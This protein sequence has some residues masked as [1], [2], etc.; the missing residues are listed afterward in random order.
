MT[1]RLVS[2]DSR[3]PTESSARAPEPSGRV[4]L[5]PLDTRPV[6]PLRSVTDVTAARVE[7]LLKQA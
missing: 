7:T 6:F 5:N 4:L 3:G 2:S 1:L